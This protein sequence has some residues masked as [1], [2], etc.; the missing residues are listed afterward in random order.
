LRRERAR[1]LTS[2]TSAGLEETGGW[3][4]PAQV[5]APGPGDLSASPALPTR[6]ALLPLLFHAV[7]PTD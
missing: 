5:R 4:T 6:Y 2:G 7:E 3:H 1:G